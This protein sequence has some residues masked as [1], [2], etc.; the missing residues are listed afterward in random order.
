MYICMYIHR[1]INVSELSPGKEIKRG[2]KEELRK[3]ERDKRTGGTWHLRGGFTERV[4]VGK[5]G[6]R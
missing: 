5:G 6:G 3:V 2:R 4:S 1:R